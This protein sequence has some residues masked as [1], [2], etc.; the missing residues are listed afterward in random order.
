MTLFFVHLNFILKYFV[1]NKFPSEHISNLYYEKIPGTL[2]G[3]QCAFIER[4]EQR[5]VSR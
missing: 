1:W 4:K 5:A 3:A 2:V